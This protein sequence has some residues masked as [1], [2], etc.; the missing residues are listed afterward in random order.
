MNIPCS[1]VKSPNPYDSC[2]GNQFAMDIV[3]GIRMDAN[4]EQLRKVLRE[5]SRDIPNRRLKKKCAA[6]QEEITRLLEAVEVEAWLCGQACGKADT[7][8][9][10]NDH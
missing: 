9:T 2:H 10:G 7:S 4:A 8:S 5:L 6:I 3:R 1:P